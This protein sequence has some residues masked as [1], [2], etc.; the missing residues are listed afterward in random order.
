[1]RPTEPATVAA[2]VALLVAAALA[3]SF[4]PARWAS[5]IDPVRALRQD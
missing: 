5:R 2:M 3:A 1:M 4:L